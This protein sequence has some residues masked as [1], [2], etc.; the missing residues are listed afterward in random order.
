MDYCAEFKVNKNNVYA[1]EILA[2]KYKVYKLRIACSEFL[3][4]KY[5]CRKNNRRP[6]R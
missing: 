2:E 3:A 1:L 4:T 6:K 5:E